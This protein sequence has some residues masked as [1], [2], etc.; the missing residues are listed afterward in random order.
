MKKILSLI[1]AFALVLTSAA[2][3]A[4][5]EDIKVYLN[6]KRLEMK[7]ADGNTVTPVVINGTTY[8][9]IRA[10]S[11]ALEVDV[12]WDDDAR[13]VYLTS[14]GNE[15]IATDVTIFSDLARY[16]DNPYEILGKSAFLN[17]LKELLGKDY[18][19][20][21]AALATTYAT[22]DGDMITLH[23][24]EKSVID[25]Y[26]DGRI[27]V[28]M[29][30]PDD[31]DFGGTN[32]VKYYS[33]ESPDAVESSGLVEFISQ[34]VSSSDY[35]VVDFVNGSGAPSSVSGTYT[36]VNG[37]GSFTFTAEEKSVAFK[38]SIKGSPLGNCSTSGNIFLEHGSTVC[39]EN[40]APAILFSFSGS[41][42]TVIGLN[43]VTKALTTVYKK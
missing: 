20:L 23:C 3:F 36:D 28:A 22:G 43:S 21:V 17:P 8:L 6:G 27:D 42:L 13:A 2:V 32:V 25:I 29:L 5:G 30:S 16:V 4:D 9:P 10:I 38:G 18:D 33:L 34:N 37:F 35:T 1:L 31:D 15:I 24:S 39:M 11:E 7:D 14:G 19:A 12:M 41:S 40:G 26:K